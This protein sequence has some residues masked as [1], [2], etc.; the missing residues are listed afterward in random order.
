[1]PE[2]VTNELSGQVEG[3]NGQPKE[4]TQHDGQAEQNG[5]QPQE[6]IRAFDQNGQE[7]VIPREEWRTNVLPQMLADLKEQPDQL[8]VLILN[9]MNDGFFTEVTD[10]AAHLYATDPVKARGTCLWAIVLIQQRRL[11]EAEQVLDAY[12]Q[13]HGEDGAVLMNLAKVYAERGDM[14]KATTTL[15]HAIELEPNLENG[16]GWYAAQEHEKGGEDAANAAFERI[17]KIE[18]SWRAQ[19]WL[20]RAALNKGQPEDALALY[21]EALAAAPRPVP[22]DFLMQMSGDLGGRGRLR[23]L[24]ELT[25]PHF[26]PEVHGLQV[27]NN[28]IKASIDSGELRLAKAVTDSLHA[29]GRPDWRPTLNFWEGAIAQAAS[30]NPQAAQQLSGQAGAQGEQQAEQQGAQIAML[31]VDGPVWLRAG[32]EARNSFAPKPAGGPG[33][34]FLGGSAE[35]PEAPIDGVLQMPDLLGRLTRALPLFLS[36]QVDLRTVANSRAV[37]PW[38]VPGSGQAGEQAGGFVV[39][40]ESWPDSTAVQAIAGPEGETEYVV[41]VHIDG[42]VKPWTAVLAFVRVRDGVRIGELDHEFDSDAP[43]EGLRKLADE[44]VELLRAAAAENDAPG[45]EVPHGA[46]F[47]DYLLRLESLLAVRCAAIEGTAPHFLS[48]E[49]AI[50]EGVRTLSEQEPKN[51]AVSMLASET[52]EAMRMVRP[53]LAAEFAPVA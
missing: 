14:E 35:P 1:M 30:S 10:S 51:R 28:L 8:Y 48:G 19:L 22:A 25:T 18:G 6:G 34:A 45:Y 11:D 23:E 4:V 24:L 41:S 9:S 27:G 31:R 20:A 33:I 16:I 50:L 42:E 40:G 32:E 36:E 46:A 3:E 38:A 7:V 26:V 43:E 12:L 53:E 5:Q 2:D 13:T 15:W 17:R 49:R 29:L 47:T 52:L 44:V 39:S 37:L 21:N